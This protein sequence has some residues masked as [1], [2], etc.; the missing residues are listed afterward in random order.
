MSKDIPSVY[1]KQE[2]VDF[3]SAREIQANDWIALADAQNKVFQDHVTEMG[4]HVFD[5]R[6]ET[7]NDSPNQTNEG[8]SVDAD[9]LNFGGVIS[10]EL[11]GGD[12]RWGLESFGKDVGIQATFKLKEGGSLTD[13]LTTVHTAGDPFQYEFDTLDRAG[14]DVKS[15]GQPNKIEVDIQW[16]A[17]SEDPSSN[18]G[19]WLWIRVGGIP[20]VQPSGLP[21]GDASP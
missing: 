15:S 5:P 21:S 16:K 18:P 19:R 20:K 10:K 14:S 11:E 2:R 4:C 17:L 7:T 12:I 6:G 1:Q 8:G 3:Q 9:R 13:S